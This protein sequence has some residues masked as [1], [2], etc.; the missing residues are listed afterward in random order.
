MP[1]G[2]YTCFFKKQMGEGEKMKKKALGIAIV[3][4]LLLSVASLTPVT[5]TTTALKTAEPDLD[6]DAISEVL[7]QYKDDL[8]EIDAYIQNYIAKHGGIDDNFVL[9]EYL[10]VK[11]DN[12]VV[13]LKEIDEFGFLSGGYTGYTLYWQWWGFKLWLYL[14][15]YWTNVLNYLGPS[16]VAIIACIISIISGGYLA[17]IA[18]TAAAII[19][20]LGVDWICDHDQG[21][22]VVIFVQY[23][24]LFFI[25]SYATAWAQ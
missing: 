24:V 7:L 23:S 4:F 17:P 9:P 3:V 22:G 11:F 10:Q 6:F 21:N 18:I 19:F 1:S 20:A 12:I 16:G 2:I 8:A 13:A 14:D 15:H 25:P 5:A